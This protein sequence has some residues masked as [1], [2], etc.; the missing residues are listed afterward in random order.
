MFNRGLM[1]VFIRHHATVPTSCFD[2]I[3]SMSAVKE[4]NSIGTLNF[5]YHCAL[6]S[7]K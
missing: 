2:Y 1:E 6:Q 4:K 3:T 5:M 7:S